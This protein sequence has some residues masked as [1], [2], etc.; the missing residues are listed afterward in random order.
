MTIYEI[1]F[2]PATNE[3]TRFAADFEQRCESFTG[4]LRGSIRYHSSLRV[5]FDATAA[6]AGTDRRV[7]E[8]QPVILDGRATGNVSQYQWR[9]TAGTAV[10][11]RN[12]TGPQASFDAPQV[13]GSGE[14]LEFELQV[15]DSAN[16]TA[17]DRTRIEVVDRSRLQTLVLLDSDPGEWVGNGEHLTLLAEDFDFSSLSG[18]FGNEFDLNFNGS[19]PW[20]LVFGTGTSAPFAV[21][22]YD[23][24]QRTFGLNLPVVEVVGRGH[25]CNIIA[26]R[27]DVSD[28]VFAAGLVD[29]LVLRFSQ[30]CDGSSAEL[31]GLVVYR[32]PFPDAHAGADQTANGGSSVA[33]SASQSTTAAGTIAGYAWRQ[34]AGAPVSISSASSATTSFTAPQIAAGTSTNLEF[35]L[36]VTDSRGLES[37]DRVF[38]TVQGVAGTSP[39]PPPASGGGGG[40]GG[41]SLDRLA[42]L[43]LLL[44]ILSQRHRPGAAQPSKE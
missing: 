4:F 44:L 36:K 25:G 11:L 34:V 33:L 7:E 29:R 43:C 10:T 23:N 20:R 18:T 13:S 8:R 39:P 31:R 17:T 22:A 9:Q 15:R 42:L 2:A 16:V 26:G 3:I 28:V 37:T 35:E 12:A 19:Q 40:G 38:V 1:S 14:T 6:F 30:F 27:F 5:P 21:R 41:G 24:A 32:S